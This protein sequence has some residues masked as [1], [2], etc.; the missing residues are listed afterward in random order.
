M[1]RYGSHLLVILNNTHLGGFLNQEAL[2]SIPLESDV[3]P[4]VNCYVYRVGFFFFV[5]VENVVARAA[6]EVALFG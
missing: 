1:I 4:I 3:M 6:I 5:V 2:P